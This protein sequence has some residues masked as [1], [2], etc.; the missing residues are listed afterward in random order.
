MKGR[1]EL[2][3][4]YAAAVRNFEAAASVLTAL[5]SARIDLLDEARSAMVGRPKLGLTGGYNAITPA[6]GACLP[7]GMRYDIL[8]GTDGE[9]AIELRGAGLTWMTLEAPLPDGAEPATKCFIE[10]I[11]GADTPLVAD[12]FLRSFD[13]DGQV[14]DGG[15][16]EWRITRDALSLCCLE[17][18]EPDEGTSGHRVIIHLRHPPARLLLSGLAITLV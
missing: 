2:T 1:F 18:P 15:H 17:L 9:T 4:L 3:T 8:P 7:D 5:Q 16:R 12:V 10:C 13:E 6:F 11:A 14:Q